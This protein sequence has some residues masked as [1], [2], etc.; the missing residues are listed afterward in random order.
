MK[1]KY[2]ELYRKINSNSKFKTLVSA[3][4]IF[5]IYPPLITAFLD[6]NIP[7]SLQ[8]VLLDMLFFIFPIFIPI[9]ILFVVL[10]FYKYYLLK[11]LLCLSLGIAFP[12]HIVAGMAVH[13]KQEAIEYF[14]MFIL[15]YI[16]FI[17]ALF[18]VLFV[19]SKLNDELNT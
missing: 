14:L 9:S 4:L 7:S 3:L 15:P 18:I 16:L 6:I 19:K 17:I 10:F 2:L 11:I 12:F 13:T 8:S 1:N 5:I